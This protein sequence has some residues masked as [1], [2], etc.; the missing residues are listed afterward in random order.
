MKSKHR[1]PIAS[2]PIQTPDGTFLAHYSEH[3]LM[4]LDFL[5]VK[6]PSAAWAEISKEI[7]A[8]ISRWHKLTTRALKEALLGKR[9]SEAPPYDLDDA[10]KFQR[11]VWLALQEIPAGETKTYGE[12][13]REMG[14]AKAMR[15][16][17]SG[18]GANPLPILIPCHRMVAV[19]GKIGG[20]SG[21][22]KWKEMLLK[23]EGVLFI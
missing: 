7:R 1:L 14:N 4:R 13:A 15:A 20:F 11:K 18:C 2:L 3:G 19:R 17:G 8:Q 9:I 22:V 5:T 10:T 6:N 12:V 21:G 23:R 16:V